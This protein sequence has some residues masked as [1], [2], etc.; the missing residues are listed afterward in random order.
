MSMKE[1]CT[2]ERLLVLQCRLAGPDNEWRDLR[3]F[4]SYESMYKAIRSGRYN[5]PCFRYRVMVRIAVYV[6]VGFHPDDE[7]CWAGGGEA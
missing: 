3:V 4:R 7:C 1:N 5:R 2:S 6:D